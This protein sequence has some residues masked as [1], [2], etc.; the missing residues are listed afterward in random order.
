MD[1]KFF[2]CSSVVLISG[3]KLKVS[4]EKGLHGVRVGVHTHF[5]LVAHNHWLS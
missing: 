1:L 5:F 4:K 2:F 3:G